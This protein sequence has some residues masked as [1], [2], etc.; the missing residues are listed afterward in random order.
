MTHNIYYIT[1]KE[2]EHSSGELGLQKQLI[3]LSPMNCNEKVYSL[4]KRQFYDI[5]KDIARSRGFPAEVVKE[6]TKEHADKLFGQRQYEKAI[7]SYKRTIGYLNP[8]YVIQNFIKVKQ[9][10]HLSKYLEKLLKVERW[11]ITRKE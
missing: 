2:I 6:I 9:L 8:S 7:K 3:K 4:I 10:D 11:L 1:E 5:A